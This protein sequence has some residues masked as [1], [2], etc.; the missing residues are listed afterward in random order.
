MLRKLILFLTPFLILFI[1]FLLIVLFI[2]RDNGKGA[3]QVA[4]NQPSQVF[5]DD[6]Y[7]GKTPLCLC[8]LAQ[9]LKT[10]DYDVKLVPGNST[11]GPT[12]QKLNIYDGVLTFFD[13]N[14]D[15]NKSAQSQSIITLEPIDQD[16]ESQILVVSFP[17]KAQVFLD[18]NLGGSTPLLLKK[19]TASDHEIK[20]VKDGYGAKDLRIKTVLGKRLSATIYL[21]IKNEVPSNV[22]SPSAIPAASKVLI[23]STPT[24]YLRVRSQPSTTASQVGTVSPGN[25]LNLVSQADGWYE[26]ELPN[27][28]QGWVS[29]DFAKKQ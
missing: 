17:D 26:I 7:I 4:A 3:L 10:K 13:V 24:G 25:V 9:L 18:G 29:S 12:E 14:F 5:L 19:I 20:V 15:K 8:E 2:N 28:S 22:A 1:I 21:G 27:G 6:K 11:F 16:K 23:L